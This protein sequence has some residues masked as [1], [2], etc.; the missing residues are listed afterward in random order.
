MLLSVF[1]GSLSAILIGTEAG[2]TD[3]ASGVF[4]DL[5]VTGRERLWLFA[6]RVPAALIV[7]MGLVFR[8]ARNLDPAGVALS[9]DLP[10]PSATYVIDSVLWVCVAEA[11]LCV[12][13][14]GLGSLTGSRAASLTALIGWQVIAGRLLRDD[15]LL[16]LSAAT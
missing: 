13:A 11:V 7:T 3:L 10:T 9:G 16:W 2:T 12:I 14:V 1:F 4:R 5:V 6:V 8:G 15:R